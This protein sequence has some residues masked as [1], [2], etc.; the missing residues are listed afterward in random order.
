MIIKESFELIDNI[1]SNTN[2]VIES[3]EYLLSN[4]VIDE[5]EY[6]EH[7]D[8][9]DGKELVI[10][11]IKNL[12]LCGKGEV[13]ILIKPRYAYVIKFENC[14]NITLENLIIGHTPDGYCA[15]GV[16]GFEGCKNINIENC[17]LFGCGTIGI[18]CVNSNNI[19]S[20]NTEIYECT[21]G[22][23]ELFSCENIIFEKNKFYNNEGFDMIKISNS[24]EIKFDEVTIT[25]NGLKTEESNYKLFDIEKSNIEIRDTIIE[26]NKIKYI[27]DKKFEPIF[28]DVN[29][30]NNQCDEFFKKIEFSNK[31]GLEK[32]INEK[33]KIVY[34][35]EKISLT[36]EIDIDNRIP[37]E[38]ILNKDKTKIIYLAPFDFETFSDLYVYDI[39]NK[40]RECL[41]SAEKIKESCNDQT[42]KIKQ[43]LWLN[44]DEIA[45]II[46]Y[47]YGTVSEG[48][49]VYK[50]YIGKDSLEKIYQVNENEEIIKIELYNDN[51][52]GL[53]AKLN[54]NYVME[55]SERIR[56]L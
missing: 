51:L 10:K 30:I 55:V 11:N 7:R 22:I 33:E 38:P 15:G 40:Q 34:N 50:Y 56:I 48:G 31:R 3:G 13:S 37:S 21:Y 54:E 16:L 19:M 12:K 43:V 42:Y 18:N 32:I 26:N 23:I 45:M 35:E 28:R 6:V 49:S 29:L 20:R 2:I 17:K 36:I 4:L 39:R 44:K 25:E 52:I 14:E 8:V 27:A 24:T 5:D 47:G 9:L 53:K 46:G 41:L 1:E